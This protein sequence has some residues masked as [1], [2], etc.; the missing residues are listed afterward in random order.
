M[1]TIGTKVELIDKAAGFEC[2]PCWEV[3]QMERNSGA[4]GGVLLTMEATHPTLGIITY[5]AGIA[6]VREINPNEVWADDIK[7]EDIKNANKQKYAKIFNEIR[8]IKED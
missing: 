2:I 5:I 8:I 3:I 6:G 1:I 7:Y 4:N